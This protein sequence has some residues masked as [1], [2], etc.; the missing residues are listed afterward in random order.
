MPPTTSSQKWLP[1]AI[2]ANQT[3][4]GQREPDRLG[5][6]G[7]GRRSAITRPT[8]SASAQ[9]AARR[10]RY[11]LAA[12]STRPRLP[13]LSPPKL[14]SVSMKPSSGNIRRHGAEQHVADQAEH[15]R[16]MILFEAG[17]RL[18]P[19]QVDPS[20]RQPITVNSDF[21]YVAVSVA[22]GARRQ[23]SRAQLAE[24]GAAPLGVDHEPSNASVGCGR[25][26]TRDLVAADPNQI[27]SSRPKSA[28]PRGRTS[29]LLKQVLIGNTR[30]QRLANSSRRSAPVDHQR[31]PTRIRVVDLVLGSSWRTAT[32]SPAAAG[33]ARRAA[34]FFRIPFSA[35][36]GACRSWPSAVA[37]PC[38]AS[39]RMVRSPVDEAVSPRRRRKRSQP[40]GR[41]R[42][43]R[44]PSRSASVARSGRRSS[45]PVDI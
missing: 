35:R 20:R 31:L 18:V 15:V 9:S 19:S 32:S 43:R 1:V 37:D 44:S 12:S 33:P 10:R 11:G 2:T 29:A 6:L 7:A 21:Q 24:A 3:Q 34:I 42:L 22:S 27:A 45:P 25:P 8:I 23:R 14:D 5:D 40:H 28:Q 36:S 39:S 41:G 17:E 26:S 13:S 38:A 16:S 30:L 4:A